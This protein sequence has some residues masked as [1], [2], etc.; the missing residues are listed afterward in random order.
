MHLQL[1]FVRAI[2]RALE[3]IFIYYL[4]NKTCII[5]EHERTYE[6]SVA[7]PTV[8]PTGTTNTFAIATHQI[9]D[10]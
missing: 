6:R 10:D 3:R 9:L 1:T 5:N 7:R 2:A 4:L 8:T